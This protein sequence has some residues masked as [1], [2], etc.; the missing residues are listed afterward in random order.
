MVSYYTE[1]LKE[2]F[3]SD[4]LRRLGFVIMLHVRSLVASG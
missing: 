2:N 4:T 3:S 1:P